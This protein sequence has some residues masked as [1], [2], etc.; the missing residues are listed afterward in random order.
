MHEEIKGRINL[1][2]YFSHSLQYTLY[3]SF[4]GVKFAVPYRASA[5][6]VRQHGAEEDI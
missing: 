6:A 4:V 5:K 1:G 3:S 2:N